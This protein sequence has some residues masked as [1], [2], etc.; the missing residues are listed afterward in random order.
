MNKRRRILLLALPLVLGALL[1]GAKWKQMHP[2]ATKLDLQ[3]RAHLRGAKI[4]N[5]VYKGNYISIPVNEFKTTLDDFYLM[6][7]FLNYSSSRIPATQTMMIVR[8]DKDQSQPLAEIDL[9][10]P[11]SYMALKQ[12]R[13]GSA[14]ALHPITERRLRELV[15]KHLPAR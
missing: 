4:V 5:L 9:D 10:V 7:G 13:T 6:N 12:N 2:T 3:E 1:G 11:A 15:A 14:V 8:R